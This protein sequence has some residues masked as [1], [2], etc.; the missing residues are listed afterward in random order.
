M[1]QMQ[2]QVCYAPDECVAIGRGNLRDLSHKDIFYA[3]LPWPILLVSKH[4]FDK[5]ICVMQ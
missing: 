3:I 5:F 2:S 1:V 4:N